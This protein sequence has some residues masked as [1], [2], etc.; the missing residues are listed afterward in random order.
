MKKFFIF[1]FIFINIYCVKVKGNGNYNLYY[2][3]KTFDEKMGVE[4]Y[5]FSGSFDSEDKILF[6]LKKLFENGK[7]N[8]NY[9]PK[10]SGILDIRLYINDLYINFNENISNY[11]GSHYEISFIKQ[12]LYNCFQFENVN[13]V[14]FLENGNIL[15]LPEGN[16]IFKYSKKNL[17]LF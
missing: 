7:E 11:S 14:T 15:I 16:I 8:I 9:I 1:T 3:E 6:L 4:K 10:D 5:Q 13:S 17:D 12:I 2:L